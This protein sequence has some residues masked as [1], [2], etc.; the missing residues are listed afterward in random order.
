MKVEIPLC[1]AKKKGVQ[2]LNANEAKVESAEKAIEV[3][4]FFFGF[5]FFL[6]GKRGRVGVEKQDMFGPKPF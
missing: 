3:E 2:G 5:S 4:F 6:G 1:S